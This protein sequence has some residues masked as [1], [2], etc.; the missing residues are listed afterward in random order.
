M[1]LRRSLPLQ[2]RQQLT[3]RGR[4]EG[5]SRLPLW[6]RQPYAACCGPSILDSFPFTAEALMRSRY[7]AYALKLE[8]L[9]TRH[10]ASDDAAPASWISSGR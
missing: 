1:P 2:R 10:L 9:S 5:A 6:Q 4:H 8:G 7:S 3:R